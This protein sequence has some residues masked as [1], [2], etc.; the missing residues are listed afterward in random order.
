MTRPP[1]DPAG[2]S[3][4]AQPLAI[5]GIELFP[6]DADAT[7]WRYRPR[8]P[9]LERQRDGTPMLQV[10]EAGSTAFLQATARVALDETERTGL[11]DALRR[12]RPTASSLEPLPLD[13]HRI[14][15][16]IKRDDGWSVL[17]ESRGSGSAPW[18]AALAAVLD[19]AGVAALKAATEGEPGRVRLV[20]HASEAGSPARTHYANATID[21]KTETPT[22]RASMAAS[23]DIDRSTPAAASRPVELVADLSDLLSSAAA[24]SR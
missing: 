1:Q 11:L 6:L 14:A 22:E 13:V 4:D 23:I 16:E 2:E 17:A 24:R 21:L 19:P 20:A 5:S 9:S 10:I 8:R 15:L 18:T 7:R 12:E 3:P